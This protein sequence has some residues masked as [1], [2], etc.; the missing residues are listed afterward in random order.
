MSTPNREL[1]ASAFEGGL[2]SGPTNPAEAIL[3][4]SEARRGHAREKAAAA[5]GLRQIFP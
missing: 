2:R 1:A 3:I 4:E 5:K